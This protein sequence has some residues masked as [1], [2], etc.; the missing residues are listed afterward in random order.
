MLAYFV[1]QK[2][3]VKRTNCPV[4]TLRGWIE[5]G[6]VLGDLEERT[7]KTEVNSLLMSVAFFLLKLN[8]VS[9][10]SFLRSVSQLPARSLLH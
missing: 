5:A 3:R 7:G 8:F 2:G 1:I 4:L 6:I 10:G 9:G